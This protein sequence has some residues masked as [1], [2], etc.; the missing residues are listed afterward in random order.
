MVRLRFP[1]EY[2]SRSPNGVAVNASL[3]EPVG[4]LVDGASVDATTAGGGVG[5]CG[6]GNAVIVAAGGPRRVA[7]WGAAMCGAAA[8]GLPAGLP[9]GIPATP[10]P[11]AGL[12]VA[13]GATAAV[14]EPITLGLAA[15]GPLKEGAL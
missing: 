6:A 8:Y 3:A 2:V 11:M 4:L 5:V 15:R 9:A 13:G 10:E 7:D 12:A 14:A 1:D